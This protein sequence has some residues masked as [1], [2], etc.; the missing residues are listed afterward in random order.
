[1]DIVHMKVE[2]KFVWMESGEQFVMTCGTA[3]MLW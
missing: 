1:M 2:L 3:Q